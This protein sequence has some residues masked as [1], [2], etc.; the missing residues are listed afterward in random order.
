[1]TWKYIYVKE[2]LV[3]NIHMCSKFQIHETFLAC[4]SCKRYASA[5]ELR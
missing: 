2:E 5:K 4:A 3:W 1:M